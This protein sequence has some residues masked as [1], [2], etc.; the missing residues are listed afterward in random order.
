MAKGFFRAFLFVSA[1]ACASNAGAQQ[2]LA[3]PGDASGAADET[4]QRP[5]SVVAAPPGFLERTITWASGKFD[6]ASGAKDG[7]YPEFG[8]LITGSGWSVGPGYRQHVFGGSAVVDVSAS[9]SWRRYTMMQSGI[10]W[11]RLAGDHLSLGGQVKYQDFTQINFFGVGA[12]SLKSNRTDYRLKDVD[13]IG[14]A[15][16]R[17]DRWLSVTGSA[18]LLRRVDV[19]R[20]TSTLYPS[21]DT[22][23]DENGAPGLT[24]QPSYL[25]TEIAVQGDT[26]DVPGYPSSG[27]RYR[28]SAATFNDRDFS[29]YS[30]RRVEADAAQYVPIFSDRSV[31][32]LRGRLDLTQTADGQVVPFYLLPSL[33]GSRTLRGYLDYRFRDRDSLLMN[34]EYRFPILRSLDGA[35]FYDAGAVAP[36]MHALGSAHLNR[37][38]GFGLRVHSRNHMLVRVDLARGQEGSR[39]LLAFSTPF[40]LSNH[41]V[42]PYVP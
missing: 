7:F 16:I 3:E 18:G 26:R 22:R 11:P 20:G 42:V 29:R 19:G 31:L 38:Y 12:D 24:L 37:D 39:A 15:T 40:G 14:F 32:A 25:H 9:I 27:G 33:G 28:L 2:A 5:Q 41:A 10:E 6:G 36:T 4:A 13:A 1:C 35:M 30:F 21:T 8:G 23:F 34:A 17:A